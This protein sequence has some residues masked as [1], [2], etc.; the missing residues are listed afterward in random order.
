MGG[1]RS[2][3]LRGK[4]K[5]ESLPTA[6]CAVEGQNT[7]PEYIDALARSRKLGKRFQ[8]IRSHSDPVSVVKALVAEK[9]KERGRGEHRDNW[10]AVFDREFSEER[11]ES[12]RRAR[13]L[14]AKHGI[15]CIESNPAF[16]YW[17]RLHFSRD[18]RPYGSADDLIEDLRRFM[19]AYGKGA[20]DLSG[21]MDEL[22]DRVETA[23][24]N[25]AW[26]KDNGSFGN[27]TEMPELV[28]IIDS[29]R[30][31]RQADGHPS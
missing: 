12:I 31:L 7:E 8:I 13:E 10:I 16:E 20:G 19:P 24:E 9:K 29:M 23:C 25:A 4:P 3:F 11:G 17:L 30:V 27:S 22:L 18:D 14:A 21:Q 5:R 28:K 15:R 1:K 26:M 6:S 2:K